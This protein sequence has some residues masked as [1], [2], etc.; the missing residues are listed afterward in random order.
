MT[1]PMKGGSA[2]GVGVPETGDGKGFP[3]LAG[4]TKLALEGKSGELKD[5]K[6]RKGIPG[7]GHGMGKGREV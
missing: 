6:Q 1:R 2:Q 3:H 5:E 7:R 4:D